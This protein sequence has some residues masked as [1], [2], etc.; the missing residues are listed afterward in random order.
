MG[1]MICLTDPE[2]SATRDAN[3]RAVAAGPGAPE[4]TPSWSLG[5]GVHRDGD[6]A[7]GVLGI[8]AR[9]QRAGSIERLD[10]IIGSPRFTLLSLRADPSEHLG[11]EAAALWQRLGGV[12]VHVGPDADYDDV[13]GDYVSW[14]SKLGVELV[15]VRPDFY[16]FGGGAL[17]DAD[18][19][20][21]EL[22][23]QLRLRQ[24]MELPPGSVVTTPGP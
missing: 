20:V 1:Q 18:E 6:P 24:E 11:A 7:G 10:D 21:L 3:L 4:W 23:G 19:L 5:P 17:E 13:D 8:Q 22:A 9:V 14:F 16:V 15:L 12:S 2:Q